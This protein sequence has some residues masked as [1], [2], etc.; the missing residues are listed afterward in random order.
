[1]HACMHTSVHAY[2]QCANGRS[3]L[4]SFVFFLRFPFAVLCD[5]PSRNVGKSQLT[6]QHCTDSRGGR[7]GLERYLGT[8]GWAALHMLCNV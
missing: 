3:L 7:G 1:M 8:G 4:F 6:V 2:L 5:V